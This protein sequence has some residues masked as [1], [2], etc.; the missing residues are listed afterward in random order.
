MSRGHSR[1]AS[2]DLNRDAVTGKLAPHSTLPSQHNKHASGNMLHHVGNIPVHPKTS[3]G[4]TAASVADPSGEGALGVQGREDD[5]S[6]LT[7]RKHASSTAT[8]H[9]HTPF[10]QE[11]IEQALKKVP[12]F[13]E[14]DEDGAY[15]HV[16]PT[17]L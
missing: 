15:A 13:P 2:R 11:E 3:A 16:K 1:R 4:A 17:T 6:V 12:T 14:E 7:G 9:D 10:S 8:A 5:G